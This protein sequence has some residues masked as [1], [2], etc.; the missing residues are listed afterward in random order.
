MREHS[1]KVT[2]L[3]LGMSAGTLAVAETAV[4]LSH[5][6]PLGAFIGAAA[7]YVAWRHGEDFVAF[8]RGFLP[9]PSSHVQAEEA[10][11]PSTDAL[12]ALSANRSIRDRLLGRFPESSPVEAMPTL[13]RRNLIGVTSNT[14]DI[15]VSDLIWQGFAPAAEQLLLALE[16]AQRHVIVNPASS[17]HI[18]LPGPTGS[19]KTNIELLLIMQL[20]PFSYVYWV[21]PMW[22]PVKNDKAKTD[23]RAVS[24]LLSG[25][26]CKYKA[27]PNF[28]QGVLD[29][30]GQRQQE[31]RDGTAEE[32]DPVWIV[33]D[34]LPAIVSECG[35]EIPTAVGKILRTGRQYKVFC[36]VASTD[37][38]VQTIGL[39]SGVQDCFRT[40]IA[41]GVPDAMTKKY[42]FGQETKLDLDWLNRGVKG[43][44]IISTGGRLTYARVP[45]ADNASMYAFLRVD[46]KSI[47]IATFNVFEE[48]CI[49]NDAM[50]TLQPVQRQLY[51]ATQWF[52]EWAEFNAKA[53]T[54]Q[55]EC[56]EHYYA[57]CTE[58]NAVP[59]SREAF[60][61][62]LKKLATGA[63]YKESN[64]SGL[65]QDGS[66]GQRLCYAGLL[67]LE[68]VYD[69]EDSID[70]N[71]QG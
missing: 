67:L 2:R 54:A 41:P 14:S 51:D 43:N 27:M 24:S 42:L 23:L 66:R 4:A 71:D 70:A 13:S 9:L 65:R 20:I 28:F 47:D 60:N 55:W 5:A 18:A 61:A 11:L 46:A 12:P 49:D 30:I 45:Y 64:P 39:S 25:I 10:S 16:D 62:V 21:N 59:V 33:I 56:Y 50:E 48:H 17:Y 19:G 3:Q 37:F 38:Q 57:R 8:G 63:G 22:A 40:V 34:E 32:W 35:K 69:D 52:S 53:I 1:P 29:L 36:I 7:A 68:P 31:E 15:S 6:G 26:V 58:L 44:V